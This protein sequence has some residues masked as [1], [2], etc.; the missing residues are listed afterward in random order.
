MQLPELFICGW[1]SSDES[2]KKV[3]EESDDGDDIP[4]ALFNKQKASITKWVLLCVWTF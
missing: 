1:G 4:E 2:C 3:R